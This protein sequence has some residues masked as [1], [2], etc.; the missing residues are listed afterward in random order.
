MG[1]SKRLGVILLV[2]TAATVAGL[3]LNQDAYWAV[4]NYASIVVTTV[5][6]F[7]LIRQK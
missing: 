1:R 2:L 3:I 5:C 4:Y 7:T 6:G